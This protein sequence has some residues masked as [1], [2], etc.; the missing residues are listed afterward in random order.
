M[1][2]FAIFALA[3]AIGG[4]AADGSMP[5]MGHREMGTLIGA[6][7]GAVVGAIAY[8]RNRTKGA[9][10]GAVGGALAG[11]VVGRYM[12]DQKRDLEKNLSQEIKLGQARIDKLPNDVVRITMTNQTAFDT[13]STEIKPAFHSTMD[14]LADVVVR[15]N[16]TSLTVVGHTDDVG[17]NDYNQKLSERRAHSVASYLESKRVNAMR[18]ALAGKGETQ[19]VTANTTEGG[20]QA[21]RRVEIYVEPVVA[22]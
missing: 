22:G 5:T 9:L 21:N 10:V 14:K 6:A 4:C 13:N 12:D 8:D 16:K 15:Y 2:R 1:K 3:L 7:G 19:P 17:S 11:G 20:R 18:L